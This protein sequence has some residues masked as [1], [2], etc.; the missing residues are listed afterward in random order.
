MTPAVL[1][2]PSS[3]PYV[4][5]LPGVA[6]PFGVWDPA[7]VAASHVRI[8][9][10]H[11]GFEDRGGDELQDWV[12]R[13]RRAGVRVVYTVHDVDN[14]HLVD[15]RGHHDALRALACS[16]DAVLTLTHAAAARV[17]DLTGREST[18]VPHPHVVPLSRI[19][20]RRT[21]RTRRQPVY[22][23]AATCRPN[24]DVDLV[25]RLA[26]GAAR[27]GGLRVHVRTPLDDHRA[28][29][30]ERLRALPGVT[31]D[32]ADRLSD[33]DLWSRIDVAAAIVLP[34]RW[35]THSGLLEAARDLA[36][37]A[38]APAIGGL[39]EQ[40]AVA[41][42]SDGT[43]DRWGDVDVVRPVSLALRLVERGRIVRRHREL[44]R[45]LVAA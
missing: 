10:L 45:A 44:Y 39:V 19:A 36:T 14:P 30:V 32:L 23:H 24:L 9:H 18:V 25:A 12:A 11:F 5:R 27:H 22:V 2:Q 3:H 35:G 40:G 29:I 7:T 33:R 31:L 38:L 20:R 8:V 41:L 13:C 15:Q 4:R 42:D 16:A 1:H 26:P 21:V 6:R 28:G 43:F 34:Y 17:R 37:P